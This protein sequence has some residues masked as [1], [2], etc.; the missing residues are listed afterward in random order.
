M[1]KDA[2]KLKYIVC[3]INQRRSGSPSQI[4]SI[5]NGKSSS[6]PTAKPSFGIAGINTS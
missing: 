4:A 1:I 5:F 2:I 3:A 6:Q